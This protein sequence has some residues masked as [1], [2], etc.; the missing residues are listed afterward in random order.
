MNGDD[1][2]REVECAAKAAVA[3]QSGLSRRTL[4]KLTGI[5]A[6][7][8]LVALAPRALF[9]EETDERLI[10]SS[11]LN[12]FI[13]VSSDGKITIA[14]RRP[15]A[16]SLRSSSASRRVTKRPPRSCAAAFFFR[17]ASPSRPS[18]RDR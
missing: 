9:A 4:F 18:P 11:E 12:A 8:A 3:E 14:S 1:M 6:G 15:G 16:S 7:F 2:I 13:T 17:G 10:V 5:G